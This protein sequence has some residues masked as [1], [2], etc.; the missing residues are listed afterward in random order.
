MRVNGVSNSA[1]AEA[2]GVSVQAVTNWLR[3]GE[4]HRD[5]LAAIAATVNC[6]IDYL[7]TGRMV[8]EQPR[9]VYG[10]PGRSP[11]R[12]YQLIPRYMVRA[13]A[14]AGA[15]NDREDIQEPI[16]FRRAWLH[17]AGLTVDT[18]VALEADGDSMAPRIGHGDLLLV[19][20][21]E[22][23]IRDG[24]IYV[25]ENHGLRVKRLYRGHDG[26]L[27]LRSDNRS[28][29]DETVAESDLRIIGR[30]VWVGGKV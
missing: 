21:A 28:F 23:G 26:R 17:G 6:S 18:L 2:A 14:G 25:I 5:R 22:L 19:Q 30:V 4:I 3:T 10:A 24:Q 29:P 11:D 20:R 16:A 13:A 1:L 15:A 7:L 9:A 27:I 12:D 8:A